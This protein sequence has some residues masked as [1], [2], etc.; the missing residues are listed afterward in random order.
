MVKGKVQGLLEVSVLIAFAA[1]TYVLYN[2]VA[3]KYVLEDMF[4]I[5]VPAGSF[6]RF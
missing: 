4:V 1:K 2:L 5:S 3:V 6:R